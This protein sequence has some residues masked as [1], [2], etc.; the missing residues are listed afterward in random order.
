MVTTG[1][2]T[3]FGDMP[4]LINHLET[5]Y[6]TETSQPYGLSCDGDRFIKWARSYLSSHRPYEVF[7]VANNYGLRL[8]NGVS[9]KV[10]PD[11]RE[12]QEVRSG[13][14]ANPDTSISITNPR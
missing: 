5:I 4:D 10:C 3:L 14:M 12:G 13:D 11:A 9:L 1:D 6:R 8:T 2:A 7:A